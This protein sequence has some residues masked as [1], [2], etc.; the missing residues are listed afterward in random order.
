MRKHLG[1]MTLAALVVLMLLLY[2]VAFQVDQLQD[3]VLVKT[4]GRVTDVLRGDERPGLHLKW[5]YPIQRVVRYDARTFVFED[6]FHQIQTKDAKNIL[7]SMYCTWRIE[8]PVKFHRA[9]ETVDAATERLRT[10]LRFYKSNVVG[11]SDMGDLV[12]TDPKK[13]ALTRIEEEILEP[14]RREAREDYGVDVR[15][16]G[17]KVVGLPKSINSAVIDS[18]KADRE[19]EVE[20]YREAGNAQATAIR[21]RARMASQQIIEF[22][23]RKAEAIRSQ[24]ERDAARYY[25]KYARNEALSIFLRSL[26]SLRKNLGENTVILLDGSELPAVK[27]FR[28]GPSLPDL[29]AMSGAAGATSR[30][31]GGN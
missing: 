27:W 21:E 11:R 28:Q 24:G 9:I 26:D 12:N 22:A 30:P 6:P 20:Q 14:L 19:K 10:H 4:F 25:E 16:V 8:D 13:M 15:M 3:V 23:K 18:Q 17:V 5:P 7:M 1:M 31:A 2:T 29:K